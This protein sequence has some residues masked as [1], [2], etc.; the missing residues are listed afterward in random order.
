MSISDRQ[1]WMF[2]EMRSGS[3]WI[4]KVFEK[5]SKRKCLHFQREPQFNTSD[6]DNISYF[7]HRQQDPNTVLTKNVNSLSD[8]TK[9]YS[10]HFF[11]ILPSIECL[12]N[13]YLIRTTRRNKA[14]HCMSLL[15]FNIHMHKFHHVFADNSI[16]YDYFLETLNNPIIV[17]KQQVEKVMLSLK[18]NDDYWNQFSKNYDNCVIVYEDLFEGIDLPQ[19]NMSFKFS[20]HNEFVLKTPD[21]KKKFF[22]NYEQIIEWCKYYEKELGL[23]VF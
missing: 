3:D 12:D 23:D 13:P 11:H 21:Y 17:L 4:W 6:K 1:I 19:F 5:L 8:V 18:K 2:R 14:E 16:G 20:E 22:A 7:F 15:Y 9:F 10:T